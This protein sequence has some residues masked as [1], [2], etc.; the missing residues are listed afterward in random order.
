MTGLKNNENNYL[1]YRL[2]KIMVHF[3]SLKGQC[4]ETPFV[5]TNSG[6][7]ASR[8]QGAAP[9]C[10]VLRTAPPQSVLAPDVS[11]AEAGDPE[12]HP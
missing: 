8:D 6:A 1:K 10:P 12:L 4:L 7:T 5:A 3:S 11:S 2:G 9:P